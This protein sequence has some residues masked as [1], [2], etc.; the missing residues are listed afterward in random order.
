MSSEKTLRYNIRNTLGLIYSF[1]VNHPQK[2]LHEIRK[3]KFLHLKKIILFACILSA[4]H[5]QGQDSLLVTKN[6]R[7]ADGIY[8]SKEELQSNA[9]ALRW[10]DLELQFF[11]NPQTS[12]TQVGKI[13]LRID[14]SPVEMDSIWGICLDGVPSVRIPR[15]EIH[16]ELPTFA[17]LKLRGNICYFT[18]PDWR[19]RLVHIAAYNPLTGRPFRTGIVEREEEVII[20]KI[21]RFNTGEMADFTVE[22]VLDWI[23][24]DPALLETIQELSDDEKREKL[25][26][27]LLIYD[28]RNEVFLKNK[29]ADID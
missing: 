6:F 15:Q 22:N 13:N 9:P 8:F 1:V 12:L 26:K 16:K 19:T 29:A 11:T 3:Q 18:Y 27:C 14:N 28:D 23:Q 4:L 21:M 17:A 20:E 7:F 2:T 24:D 25:F 10:E 5:L